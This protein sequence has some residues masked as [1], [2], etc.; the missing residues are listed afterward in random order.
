M[1]DKHNNMAIGEKMYQWAEDLFPINRSITGQ[2]VRATLD[3]I[4]EFLP[5]L[6]IESITSG[7]PVFDWVVPDEWE[8]SEAYILSSDG[9]KV[10]DFKENNLHLVGYSTAVDQVLCFDELKEHLYY[11]EE[12]PEAIPYITS[13]YKR[14]WGFCISYQ[15]FLEMS[16]KPEEK[17]KVVIKSRHFSGCLNYGVLL[18]PGESKQ[19]IFL[20]TYICHPSMANNEL[21]GPVVTM[22]LAQELLKSKTPHRY[23][24]RI[25]FIPE[26][27]GSISYLSLH[28]ETLK[29]HVI[30]GFNITCVGDDRD[31]SFMPSRLGNTLADRAALHALNYLAKDYKSYS[32]LDRGSDE[33]QYCSPGV[34]LPVCS[35]MRSKYG[36]YPEYHTSLDDLSL[37]SPR[38]LQVSF[39]IIKCAIECVEQNRLLKTSVLCEPQLGKRGLY[40]TVSTRDSHSKV[41]DMMNLIA[42]CDG[43]TD[44]IDI[45]EKIQTPL[46]TLIPII[47]QLMDHQLL[48]SCE[49]ETHP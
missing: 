47:M 49:S 32:F 19:E 13:Y 9:E 2:G 33:R 25:I 6:N 45:S 16:K 11:L 14:Q 10:V 34:D 41:R 37:I 31:I 26:T 46:W 43:N 38:G 20:S 4:K 36:E 39:D 12:L 29:R 28:L 22:A 40:P 3:Y 23:S 35:I 30:A 42:Y 7:T 5:A 27:I 18:I 24:Y 21:S 1:V 48:I 15:Q 44:L 8:V 17:F